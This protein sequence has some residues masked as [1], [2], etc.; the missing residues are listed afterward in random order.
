MLVR[1]SGLRAKLAESAAAFR[2]NFRILNSAG[3]SS[4]G[5]GRWWDSGRTASPLSVYAYEAGG[6]KAVGLSTLVRTIPAA[7]AAPFLS[8]LA[9]RLP[10]IPV[11]SASS[12]GSAVAIG[13]AGAVVL[14]DGRAWAVYALA[15][16]SSILGTLFLPAESALLPDLARD[17][18]ELTAANV[19][20]STIESVGSFVGPAIGGFLLAATSAGVVFHHGGRDVRLGSR[21]SSR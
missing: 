15:G 9:D 19:T 3:C 13:A 16:V 11:M 5:S 17:P 8:T 12:L 14:S 7:I 20:R 6:A 2:G 18:E 21:A 10:R 1:M 4:L